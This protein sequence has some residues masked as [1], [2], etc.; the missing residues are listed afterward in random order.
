MT[1]QQAVEMMWKHG[2]LTGPP[3]E[4]L[5][6]QFTPATGYDAQARLLERWVASGEA[7]G[8]WKIAMSAP[9]VRALFKSE[10]PGYGYLLQRGRVESGHT[11]KTQGMHQPAL[12]SEL[13]LII[14]RPLAGPG[15][16]PAMARAAVGAV[17]PA[18]ELIERRVDPTK[19]L[20]LLIADNVMQFAW[21]VGAPVRPCP[22]GLDSGAVRVVIRRN[23]VVEQEALGKD[24]IDDIFGSLAWLANALGTRGASLKPG[25]H[26]ITGTFGKPIPV[27][28]GD[29]FQTEFSGVGRVEARFE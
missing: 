24:V 3:P 21:V 18:F 27:V 4:V 22:A 26:V 9:A 25:Q 17:A 8:G 29:R 23:G 15:V 10:T 7:Q 6:G 16:T 28:K 19:D 1:P 20:G 11:F 2:P 13:C 14:E 5:Q 12:E